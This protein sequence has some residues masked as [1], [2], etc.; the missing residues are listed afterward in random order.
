[1]P[2]QG[3]EKRIPICSCLVGQSFL[4]LD[5]AEKDLPCLQEAQQLACS[6]THSPL[7]DI[8][9]VGKMLRSMKKVSGNLR[10]KGVIYINELNGKAH[11]S[12]S[13]RKVF[14]FS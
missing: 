12:Q 14:C 8:H 4:P 13:R 3:A 7:K 10:N 2:S 9:V 11:L 1:M 6:L 5:C